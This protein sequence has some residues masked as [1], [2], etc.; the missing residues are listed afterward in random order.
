VTLYSAPVELAAPIQ[1][2]SRGGALIL[3]LLAILLIWFGI[4]PA[5]L[6]NLIRIT[7]AGL[8]QG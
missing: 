6:L 1:M 8:V 5:P 7:M 3:I 2:P 4:Y